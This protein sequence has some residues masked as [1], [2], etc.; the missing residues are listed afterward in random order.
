MRLSTACGQ[1]LVLPTFEGV[2]ELRTARTLLRQ[3]QDSDL[4]A[5][6]AMNADPA[7]R[8]H[9]SGLLTRDEALGE[10][11][12]ARISLARRGWGAWALELPGVLPFAGFVGLI[13]PAWD[14]HFTP[15]VEIG[16]RLPQ[17]AWGRGYASEAAAAAAAFAFGMLGL[18]EL[19]AITLPGNEPSRRVMSRIGMRHDADGDFAHPR[20]PADHPM[21]RHVLYRLRAPA[22]GWPAR[23]RAGPDT[24]GYPRSP[25][26]PTIAAIPAPAAEALR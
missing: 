22:P 21:S 2:R 18:D 13:V 23:P 19:V 4:E 14:A 8:R 7:V 11:G 24:S 10:A 17:A 6:V 3:W 9:F 26:G 5:W 16:W 12:R 15:A 20:L 1:A 25:A